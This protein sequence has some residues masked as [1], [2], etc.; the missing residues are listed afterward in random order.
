[1]LDLIVLRD[2]ALVSCGDENWRIVHVEDS[3]RVLA[4]SLADGRHDFLK[5]ENL[6]PLDSALSASLP[7]EPDAIPEGSKAVS[8]ADRPTSKQSAF[9][10]QRRVRKL[11]NADEITKKE[12]KKQLAQRAKA[13][14]QF[15][16]VL[17]ILAKPR[18]QRRELIEDMC[19]R[20]HISS[21]AVYRKMKI[22]SVHGN[23]DALVRSV[24]KDS[25]GYHLTPE[26]QKSIK[27]HLR[28][29]RFI[30]EPKTLP[31]I[32]VLLNGDS[33]EKGW[34]KI[35]ITTLRKFEQETTLKT[36]LKSQGRKKKAA[37][38]F[39]PKVGHL[40]DN[41]YPLAI[42]Q[43]D[44]TPIQVCL[45]D[46][47]DRQP[48]GDAWLTLVIDTYS[49]M[50]LGFFLT[51]DAPSTLSTGMAL[52]HAF[53]PKEEYLRRQRVTGEW[54]SWGFPDIVIVDN[55]TELNGKMMHGARRRYRFTLRDRPV[56]SPN[57]GGHVESAFR[58]F[59]NELKAVPGTKFSNPVERG[60][61]DSEGRAIF[62]LAEFEAFFTEF[63]VNDYHLKQHRGAG[64][65]G[66][67]P[68]L[69]W[70]QG[71]FEGDV[72]PPTGL[73]DRPAD[74]RALRISLM[75]TKMRT[76]RNGIVEIFDEKYHSPA[77]TLIG[78][79][80]NLERPI[81]ERRFEIRYDPRNISTVWLYNEPTDSYI[82][83][84]SADLGNEPI[85][86]WEHNARKRRR[87]NP[88]EQF[89]DQRYQSKLRREDMKTT[90]ALRTKA[91]RLEAEKDRRRAEGAIVQ[92]P[93]RPSKPAA[94]ASRKT[95]IS[96]DRV[97]ALREKVHA[98]EVIPKK[99][100]GGDDET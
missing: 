46:E 95:R 68:L 58:T 47:I 11:P 80:V 62:T 23:A 72:L 78:D 59:M 81:D 20:L 17:K 30:K 57:F 51:L 45:V 91:R 83:L 21:A 55:A 71:V 25:G 37:D 94:P 49:R 36:K 9:I 66:T 65:D 32:L 87:G 3:S 48:I 16:D 73:P 56:G 85:S 12:N 75:P 74:P 27:T 61:Y 15:Q 19:S 24:R 10:R 92:P 99:T 13:V 70:K 54:P 40:P 22:V 14:E 88:S 84:S 26:L 38:A 41:D 29:H 97:K 79:S 28:E 4:T 100:P 6:R 90:A 31:D 76:V 8:K 77:L 39:R 96:E 50:V 93:P 5:I 1:M 33:K 34:K 35:S 43:V 89:E 69:K 64:M 86:L 82:D 67:V 44:H 98:A 53:L 42:A 2:G 63:L 7:A 60:E 52:A 18:A